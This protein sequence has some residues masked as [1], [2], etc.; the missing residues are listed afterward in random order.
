[1]QHIPVSLLCLAVL[2]S[3]CDG[4]TSL[5]TAPGP[6]T[7]QPSAPS[8]SPSPAV[9]RSQVAVDIAL[10]DVVRSHVT[11]DDPLCDPSW[12]HRCRYYRLTPPTSGV[13]NVTI[14][15]SPQVL[16]PYPLD[17]DVVDEQGRMYFPSVGPGHQR[18][19]SMA[20]TAGST[21]FIGIWSFV[22]PGEEFELRTA[23]QPQ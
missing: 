15:W 11:D 14:A 19:M 18:Q 8:P 2:A 17:V 6:V 10:G 7:P 9:P 13:L 3:G 21:Y 16:D 22:W 4:V 5:P 1:M 20:V 12:P 23:I